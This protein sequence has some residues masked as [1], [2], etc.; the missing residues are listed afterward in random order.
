MA[1]LVGDNLIVSAAKTAATSASRKKYLLGGKTTAGFDCSGFVWYV[2]DQAYPGDRFRYMRAQDYP[3]SR[4][5][6]RVE[7]EPLPGDIICFSKTPASEVHHVGIVVSARIWIGSQSSTGVA[8][9]SMSNPYWSSRSK[10]FL[11]YT[12]VAAAGA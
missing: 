9:V 1:D 7:G 2:I 10:F 6:T 12:G 5:F 11:R 4:L 3:K 8:E